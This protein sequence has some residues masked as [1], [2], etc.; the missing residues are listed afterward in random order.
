MFFSHPHE[1]VSFNYER[2]LYRVAAERRAD[3]RVTHA[4]TLEVNDYGNVVR[5][6]NVGYGR[7]FD[8]PAGPLTAAEQEMQKKILLTLSVNHYTNVVNEPDA[9]RT[10]LACESSSYE[11]IRVRPK[12]HESNITNLFRF[13]EMAHAAAI[14]SDGKHDLPFED[15]NAEG[16]IENAP[17]RR[18]FRRARSLYRSNRL[19]EILPLGDDRVAGT[20]RQKITNWFSRPGYC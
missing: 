15:L 20:A 12:S 1:S 5:S 11:L 9:Y 16:A 13:E 18:I 14:V 4:F 2:K 10:P 7:R 19:E 6:V 3:P 8:D 17:Y